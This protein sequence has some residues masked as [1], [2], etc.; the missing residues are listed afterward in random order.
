MEDVVAHTI[1]LS[2]KISCTIVVLGF[3]LSIIDRVIYNYQALLE[4]F[5]HSDIITVNNKDLWLSILIWMQN[6]FETTQGKIIADIEVFKSNKV[7]IREFMFLPKP[8]KY[9]FIDL[10]DQGIGKVWI[11]TVSATSDGTSDITGF[12]VFV[13][14]ENINSFYAHV[15][16]EA[17][18]VDEQR[19]RS[20]K[21]KCCIIDP[22]PNIVFALPDESQTH[23]SSFGHANGEYT[24]FF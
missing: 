2:S 15:M 4:K 6:H 23:N 22:P 19:I 24:Q 8:A 16:S 9:F 18:I 3:C 21:Q 11:K 7:Q 12:K 13:S 17:N 10:S 1:A 5:Y 20:F 14:K